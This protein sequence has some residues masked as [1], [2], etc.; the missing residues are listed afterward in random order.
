MEKHKHTRPG[1]A[2]GWA[3]GRVGTLFSGRAESALS[4]EIRY[5]K[6]RT[7]QAVSGCTYKL[8]R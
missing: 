2:G 1:Q 6:F 5:E 7:D 8:Q 3:S 4:N